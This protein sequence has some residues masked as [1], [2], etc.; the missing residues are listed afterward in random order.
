AVA[1]GGKR[2]PRTTGDE[3]ERAV[4][5]QP[6]PTPGEPTQTTHVVKPGDT[7][8]DL[9]TAYLGSP[10][11]WARVYNANRGTVQYPHWIYPGQKLNIPGKELLARLERAEQQEAPARED[12]RTIFY[13]KAA[14]TETMSVSEDLRPAVERGEYLA[15]PWVTDVASLGVIGSMLDRVKVEGRSEKLPQAVVIQD[16][17]YVRPVPGTT[18]AA[19][20]SELLL[21]RV[22]RALAP[23]GSIVEPTA[24]VLIEGGNEHVAVGRIVKQYAPILQGQ[25]A[26][27]VPAFTPPRA[28]HAQPVQRGPEGELI[29]F[30]HEQPLH[31]IADL[32]FVSIG[33]A[34]GLSIGDELVAYAPT[35]P[36]AA[37]PKVLL[38]PEDV[39]RLLVLRVE[40]HTATVRPLSMRLPSLQRGLK[41]RLAARVP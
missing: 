9:S 15:T 3:A 4:A 31:T 22:G 10:W 38:P 32:G 16:R 17:I 41:V 21:V 2:A 35:R 5:A 40:E 33:R 8:W 26:L 19:Q 37:D 24:L 36:A 11:A 28:G 39:A 18:P 12:D 34:E 29:D 20:G 25:R 23:F 14:S 27:P 1:R 6:A 30:V 7:L 13:R